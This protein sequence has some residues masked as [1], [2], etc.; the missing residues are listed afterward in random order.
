MEDPETTEKL[1]K[2]ERMMK[3]RQL[4]T[5][6]FFLCFVSL[7]SLWCYKEKKK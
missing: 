3:P 5:F 1:F 4:F 2:S 7:F 6:S